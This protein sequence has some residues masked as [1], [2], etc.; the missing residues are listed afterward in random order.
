MKINKFWHRLDI[1]LK[2]KVAG[3]ILA[4]L[5]IIYWVVLITE[6]NS[7]KNYLTMWTIFFVASAMSVT[8]VLFL[9]GTMAKLT[10]RPASH[11]VLGVVFALFAFS[12]LTSIFS[13]NQGSAYAKAVLVIVALVFATLSV[14]YLSGFMAKRKYSKTQLLNV[15]F[16][17]EDDDNF[18]SESVDDVDDMLFSVDCMEGHRFE[19]FCADLLRANGFTNVNVTQASGDQGVDIIATKDFVKYAFQCKN[20][21]SNL[22]NT[23][24]QEVNSGKMFY[25]CHV[26]VVLTNSTFTPGAKQLADATGVLLWDRT[27]LMQLI[28]TAKQE[29]NFKFHL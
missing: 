11:W 16:P 27:M 9:R 20:Y 10:K 26:A 12:C 24:I 19:Y 22:G 13:S 4:F 6:V 28:E 18:N 23:P 7:F 25:R 1:P 2:H 5:A 8:S 14:L 29:T 3:W 21:S 17:I 15:A